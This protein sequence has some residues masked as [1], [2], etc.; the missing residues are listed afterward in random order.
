MFIV[1]T[2]HTRTLLTRIVVP[3][4]NFGLS[5]FYSF[6]SS[7]GFPSVNYNNRK[8]FANSERK[9][10][11]IADTSVSDIYIHIRFLLRRIRCLK[12][13]CR[14]IIIIALRPRPGRPSVQLLGPRSR[15]ASPF[16]VIWR[17]KSV[18]SFFS[19]GCQ[20]PAR[21][22]GVWFQS[23]IRQ[24]IVVQAN[25]FSIKGKCVDSDGDKFLVSD[26]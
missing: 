12:M 1:W 25:R 4:T 7:F 23:G 18:F 21:W 16:S 19:E 9:N 22:E 2:K 5:V 10:I 20:F 24:S 17:L 11:K 8:M 6:V 26:E 3:A 13:Y 14:Q 15:R